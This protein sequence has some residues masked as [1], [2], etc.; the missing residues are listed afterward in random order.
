[1][2]HRHIGRVGIHFD[3]EF[4]AESTCSIIKHEGNY[5]DAVCLP[6]MPILIKVL[7]KANLAFKNMHIRFAYDLSSQAINKPFLIVTSSSI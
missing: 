1:M 6:S 4:F 3:T 5:Q 2:S 7:I